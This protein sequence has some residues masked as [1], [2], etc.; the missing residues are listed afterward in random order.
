MGSRGRGSCQ[1]I[2][3]LSHEQSWR[4]MLLSAEVQPCAVESE[5]WRGLVLDLTALQARWNTLGSWAGSLS[6]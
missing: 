1:V 4:K 6:A 3:Q 2:Q 5:H